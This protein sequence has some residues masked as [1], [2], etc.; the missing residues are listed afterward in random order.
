MNAIKSFLDE[1]SS[2]I[3]EAIRILLSHQ[4]G[5]SQIGQINAYLVGSK[6][7]TDTEIWPQGDRAFETAESRL[8][9]DCQVACPCWIILRL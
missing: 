5:R 9:G 7:I 4:F 3:D 2:Q 6:A 8:S 1:I